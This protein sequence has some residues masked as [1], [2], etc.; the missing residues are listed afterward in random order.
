STQSELLEGSQPQGS[1]C[2]RRARRPGADPRSRTPDRVMSAK[3]S[4]EQTD[5]RT[6]PKE[7]SMATST[8]QQPTFEPPGPGPWD[9]DALHFPRPVTAYWADMHPEP[10]AL[11]Y[12]DMTAYYGAPIQTRHT[13]YV[14][15]FCYGQME[16]IAPESFPE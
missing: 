9:L 14:N 16:P 8:K 15:G 6:L 1:S 11:G 5:G 4:R 10:F 13:A 3:F 2:S 7:M 12:G